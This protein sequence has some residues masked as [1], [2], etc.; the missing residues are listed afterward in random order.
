MAERFE[1]VTCTVCLE[2]FVC[3]KLLPC[4][5]TFCLACLQALAARDPSGRHLTCP[6][7]RKK[8]NVPKAGVAAFQTNFYIHEEDLA[9]A[10]ST[11]SN[12][13]TSCTKHSG[14]KLSFYCRSCE[15][16]ICQHCRQ[17]EHRHHSVDDLSHVVQ[18]PKQKLNKNNSHIEMALL[19]A[20]RE[21]KRIKQQ[22]QQF[23]DKK[24][25]VGASIRSRYA[26]LLAQAAKLRDE[27]L[28]SLDDACREK[29]DSLQEA[30]DL[31]K[32]DAQA[33]TSLRQNTQDAL[34]TQSAPPAKFQELSSQPLLQRY[35]LNTD[36]EMLMLD[37]TLPVLLYTTN[38]TTVNDCI[39]AFFGRTTIVTKNIVSNRETATVQFNCGQEV[40]L[41]EIRSVCYVGGNSVWLSFQD[42]LSENRDLQGNRR[43]QVLN[44]R[45][46]EAIGGS[47]KCTGFDQYAY[48]PDCLTS[49]SVSNV[50]YWLKP[51]K[52]NGGVEVFRGQKHSF[53]LQFYILGEKLMAFDVD[54]QEE[55]FAVVSETTDPSYRRTVKVYTK[56]EEDQNVVTSFFKT[57]VALDRRGSSAAECGGTY[58]PPNE[59]CTVFQPSDICFFSMDGYDQ[60]VLLVADEVNDAIH[61]VKVVPQ[62]GPNGMLLNR[63]KLEFVRYLAAGSHLIIQPTALNVDMQGRLWVACRGG[64]ILI[65]TSSGIE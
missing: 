3:P 1:D 12:C 9:R 6:N 40:G 50:Y 44:E 58:N 56:P 60:K 35:F 19:R 49:K 53:S 54:E 11:G 20:N 17:A 46:L 4:Y 21:T 59:V 38:I 5:H 32:K 63:R 41:T 55:L 36:L 57:L 7:C 18:S 23:Q 15:E 34:G 43:S 48:Q 8:V 65:I 64:R 39:Q 31:A 22:H 33:L 52:E 61:L 51:D 47:F 45:E 37:V 62:F 10:R 30:F 24:D 2:V 14:T 16:S 28:K 29:E 26:T 27:A 25:A 42:R 13:K